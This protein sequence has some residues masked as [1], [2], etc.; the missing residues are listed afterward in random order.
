[1]TGLAQLVVGLGADKKYGTDDDV[2]IHGTRDADG[3]I[4]AIKTDGALRIGTAF[5]NDIA[6]SANRSIR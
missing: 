5:L 3:T 2:V 4:H 1:M 6:A